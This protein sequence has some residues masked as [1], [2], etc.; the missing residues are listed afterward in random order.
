MQWI[1][2]TTA[3]TVMNLRNLPSRLGP[4]MVIVIGIAGV[5]AVLTALLA[6]AEGFQ[7]T[8]ESAGRADHAIVLRDGA[9]DEM[10]S[11][12]GGDQTD[13]IANLPGVAKGVDGQPLVSPEVFVVSDVPKR[14]TG[15]NANLPVRGVTTTAATLRE[16]FEIIEGRMFETGRAEM[17]AGRQASGQ[18]ANLEVGSTLQARGSQWRVVGIFATGGDVYESEAWIDAPVAQSAFRRGNSYQSV[19]VALENV[20]AFAQFTDALEA[21]Q[22]LQ[23]K[24]RRETDHFAA[25]SAG[26]AGSIRMFGIVVCAIMAIGAIFGALN[27]MY[28]AVSTRNVE[29]ATLR[30]LGFRGSSVVISVLVEALMLAFVGGAIGGALAYVLFNGY[31]VSTLNNASFSQVAFDFA[32]TPQLMMAGLI[33]ALVIGFVGGLLPALRAARVPITT[34]LREL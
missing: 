25:Q 3:V 8:L 14:A 22:R 6:M 10:S 9:N 5:V 33:I 4:S 30:A 12:L 20:D 29:I 11:G 26:T 31:T 32:V 23:V 24:A 34:A 7:R 1:K 13:L 28:S 17:I 27:S 2:Q 15:L 19:R 18:F 16:D 21:D